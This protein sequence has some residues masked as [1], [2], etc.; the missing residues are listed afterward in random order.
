M[1]LE[2]R[3]IEKVAVLLGRW[4]S[5]R[6]RHDAVHKGVRTLR[7]PD[8]RTDE[9]GPRAQGGARTRSVRANDVVCVEG[10][11]RLMATRYEKQAA[12]DTPDGDIGQPQAWI[13]GLR[14]IA[15]A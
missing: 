1:S 14:P 12:D 15:D 7:E 4:V 8:D 13:N 6:I 9:F 5:R 11:L 3:L 2:G 10:H